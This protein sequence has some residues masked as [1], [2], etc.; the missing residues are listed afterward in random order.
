M[1]NLLPGGSQNQGGGGIFGGK[2]IFEV[3][4]DVLSGE[5]QGNI[6]ASDTKE[7]KDVDTR[8]D[9]GAN[10]RISWNI[11]MTSDR[12][13]SHTQTLDT[14]MAEVNDEEIPG[15]HGVTKKKRRGFGVLFK[16]PSSE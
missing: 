7:E 13:R 10:G 12:T 2:S 14:T 8:N 16:G 6:N 4:K 9:S 3:F 15:E 1:T 11:T 5:W